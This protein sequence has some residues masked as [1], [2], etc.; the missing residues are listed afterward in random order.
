VV[1]T[2][3]ALTGRAAVAREVLGVRRLAVAGAAGCTSQLW[4][5]GVRVPAEPARGGPAVFGRRRAALLGR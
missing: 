3:V 2:W 5:R 4:V 1:A